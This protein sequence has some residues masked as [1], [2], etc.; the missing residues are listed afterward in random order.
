[1]ASKKFKFVLLL[2]TLFF[3]ATMFAQIP[4]G[5]WREHLPYSNGHT[6]AIT[7]T[8]VYCATELAIFYYNLDDGQLVK[9]SKINGLSDLE[10][11]SMAYYKN[12]DKLIVGYKSGN[13]DVFTGD[14]KTNFPDIK[15]KNM[16]ADKTIYNINIVDHL[17]YL[18]C[19]FGIVVF[20]LEKN[21]ISDSYVIGSGGSYMKI[22]A[23]AIYND[24]I[25]AA[26]DNGIYKAWE[27]DPFLGNYMNWNIVNGTLNPNGVFTSPVVFDQKL[28]VINNTGISDSTVVYS[29]NGSTWDSVLTHLNRVKN[30]SVSQEKLTVPKQYHVLTYG[31]NLE[32]LSIYSAHDAQQALYDDQENLWLADSKSGLLKKSADVYVSTYLPE[33]PTNNQVYDI[34]YNN[35]SVFVAPGGRRWTG[36][37]IYYWADVFEFT[38]EKWSDL[39]TTNYDSISSLRDVCNIAAYGSGS[40]YAA[41]WGYGL[42]E[43]KNKLVTRVFNS[44]NT[45]GILGNYI[46]GS[47][48]DKN[49]NLWLVNRSSDRPF[50]V[51]T[52]AGKWYNYAY[53]GEFS[54][55]TTHKVICTNNNDMWAISQRGDGIFVWNPKATPEIEADDDYRYFDVR[56]TDGTLSSEVYDIAEDQDGSI[57]LGTAN[58]VAVYDYPSSVYTDNVVY[59]RVPQLVVDGYLKDLLDGEVVTAIAVDGANRKWLGTEGGGLFLVSADGTQE[60]MSWNVDNSKLLSNTITAL[61]I[62]KLTGEVFIGTD[63]GLQSFMG[64][65][66]EAQ[67][68][69]SSIYAFPNPVKEGYD[70]LI[71]IRG[72][73]YQTNVKITDLA[74]HLVYQTISNGGDAVW[75]GKDLNGDVVQ[76]GIYLVLC[77]TASG[78]ESEATKILIVR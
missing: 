51:K 21:E 40:Y 60:I 27:Q 70:G 68:N 75:N 1:M 16:V 44:E 49:G 48:F 52:P 41:T 72:L 65:A 11:T 43:V 2:A 26:T 35:G 58:G 64:T 39:L 69:F 77:T 20:N 28:F 24:T 50:V 37:N 22:N 29:Y 18:S 59:A 71:T 10:V 57:W 34:F 8:R 42:I 36:A 61:E 23:T 17:A 53:S 78:E 9:L 15:V 13:I 31:A 67:A 7:P 76:S 73:M 25:Y 30:L 5:E 4:K 66:T 46:S 6:V 38:D 32:Q 33:G 55:K 12:T 63:L 74:G 45:E 47:V 14:D 62:N 19:G 3:A 56:D 54:N